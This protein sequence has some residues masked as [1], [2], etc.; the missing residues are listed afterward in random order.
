MTAV[1]GCCC[2]RGRR[3]RTKHIRILKM[4]GIFEVPI[5]GDDP[6]GDGQR[7]E[8]DAEQKAAVLD[9]IGTCFLNVDPEHPA[10]R[11]VLRLSVRYRLEHPSAPGGK[12]DLKTPE[13]ATPAAKGELMAALDRVDVKLPEVPSLVFELNEIIANPMSSAGDI[14]GVVNQEP[15]PGGPAAENRQFGFLTAS[16]SKIDSISRAVMLIGSKE[17]SN[18]ALGITIMETFKDI[19]RQVIDVASF[20]EHNLACGIVSRLLA[21]H[22]NTANSEQLFVSG[23]LHDIGR[24]VLCK[25]YPK[26]ATAAFSEASR[27]KQPLLKSELSLLGCTPY[28]DRQKTAQ[29]V[30]TSLYP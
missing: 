28:A 12:K 23:M 13:N 2:P 10:I 27:E 21:A 14:A 17:V 16:A 7:R 3:C 9:A 18:L 30:E 19:P 26:M 20:L 1:P 15:K 11:E 5:D 6:G 4:W 22:G 8:I 29:K 24:L 25:Y